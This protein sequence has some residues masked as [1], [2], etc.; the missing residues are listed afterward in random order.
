MTTGVMGAAV[1]AEAI[2]L[3]VA[4]DPP[5]KALW[6]GVGGDVAVQLTE[7]EGVAVTFTNVPN[8][9][10]AADV[11]MVVTTGTTATGILGAR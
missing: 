7:N 10:F 8:G 9:W 1:K 11:R 4:V 2:T 5:Y 6:I 3:D